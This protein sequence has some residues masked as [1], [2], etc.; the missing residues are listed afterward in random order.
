MNSPELAKL[1]NETICAF[2]R[3]ERAI[4]RYEH[5]TLVVPTA[6]VNQLRYAGFHFLRV[7]DLQSRQDE[8][9][10]DKAARELVE[11]KEHCDRAWFDSFDGLLATQLNFFNDFVRRGYRAANIIRYYPQYDEDS[12][13]LNQVV[14]ALRTSSVSQRMTL[15]RMARTVRAM[16]RVQKIRQRVECAMLSLDK[17]Q[18]AS[19]IAHRNQEA[20]KRYNENVLRKRE[21]LVSL[22][23][24][25]CG[26][27]IGAAGTL[28]AVYGISRYKG[29]VD[30][31]A[32]P[33][34]CTLGALA[35]MIV[36]FFFSIFAIN[37]VL[38]RMARE[39]PGFLNVSPP[40]LEEV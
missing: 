33:I 30:P 9:W 27:V 19:A 7:L 6:P 3:A 2:R 12:Q 18:T 14:L 28:I 35:M 31:A 39:C 34:L 24:T 23:A 11:A 13:F 4:K 32:H 26:M 38:N 21:L 8:G 37:R 20:I 10:R 36:C 1:R 22:S 17:E 29:V 25:L 40:K 5:L 16:R 15:Y